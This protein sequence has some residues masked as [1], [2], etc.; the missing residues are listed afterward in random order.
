MVTTVAEIRSSVEQFHRKIEETCS[1]VDT[2]ALHWKKDPDTWSVA[3]ILAHVAEFEHFFG[4]DVR[5][6]HDSPGCPF[7]RTMEDA[8][9]LNAVML[10]GNESR[11]ELLA[12]LSE[13]RQYFLTVLDDLT[14]VDLSIE[15][16]NPKFGTKSIDWVI[17]HFIVEHLE[18]HASQLQRTLAAYE[19]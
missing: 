19:S 16:T 3:Q 1:S 12:N 7:G 6:L 4:D 17:G 15:G 11:A 14:D 9:R 2:I 8:K 5:R 18:K 13:G 10:T